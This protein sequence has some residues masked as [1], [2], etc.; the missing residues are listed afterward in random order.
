VR[1]SGIG[2]SEE[3]LARLFQAFTQADSSTTRRYGGTGLGL[4]IT[5]QL[6]QLAGGDVGLRS[7]PGQGSVFWFTARLRKGQLRA[8]ETAAAWQLPDVEHRLARDCAGLRI[9]LAE[10][11]PVNRMVAL[12]LLKDSGLMVD[13]AEDGSEA[14]QLATATPYALILMDVQMP[15]LDGLEATRL[16]RLTKYHAATPILAMTAN[17]FDEDRQRCRDAGMTDF[18]TKPFQPEALYALLWQHLSARPI[19]V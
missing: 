1:D 19:E 7:V 17:A 5:R 3:V 18:L 9:L 4:A 13:T 8:A 6:A 12:A 10:D 11:E 16:I 2:M 15:Q 14:V